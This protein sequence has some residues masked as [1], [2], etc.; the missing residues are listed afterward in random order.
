MSFAR[1]CFEACLHKMIRSDAA[2]L[3]LTVYGEGIK[4]CKIDVR[5]FPRRKFVVFTVFWPATIVDACVM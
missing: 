4:V 5:L 2:N 3:G 1:L